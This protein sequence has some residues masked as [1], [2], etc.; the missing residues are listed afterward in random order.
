EGRVPVKIAKGDWRATNF[1]GAGAGCACAA[2]RSAERECRAACFSARRDL[3]FARY[4][5]ANGGNILSRGFARR[6]CF[7]RRRQGGNGRNRRVHYRSDES[8]ESNQ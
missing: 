2:K 7:C 8:D 1:D 3:T 5:F 4:R 6:A